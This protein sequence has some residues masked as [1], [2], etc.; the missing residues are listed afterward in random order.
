MDRWH[1]TDRSTGFA[2]SVEHG[3]AHAH[4]LGFHLTDVWED[5]RMKGV[6][7]RKH[8]VSLKVMERM[9]HKPNMLGVAW[10]THPVRLKLV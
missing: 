4:H 10:S 9:K 2:V 3:T 8:P 5:I 7:P 1:V 6:G